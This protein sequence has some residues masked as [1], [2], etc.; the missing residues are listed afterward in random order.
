MALSKSQVTE[1][2][3]GRL[4]QLYIC[5]KD[6]AQWDEPALV[7]LTKIINE[8]F[9]SYTILKGDGYFRL[10]PAPTLI[11][12]IASDDTNAVIAIGNKLRLAFDQEG[13]G[14]VYDGLYR[15]ILA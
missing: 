9:E 2:L 1:T 12:H 14:L 6:D 3:V 11:V 5:N 10:Q 13:V 15:R 8:R 7:K 4:H